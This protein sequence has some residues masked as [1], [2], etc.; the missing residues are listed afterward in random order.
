MYELTE[1]ADLTIIHNLDRSGA[2]IGGNEVLTD[3]TGRPTD[4]VR[5]QRPLESLI[6]TRIGIDF[7]R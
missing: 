4:I 2:M 3:E 5:M 6:F 1:H 7:V